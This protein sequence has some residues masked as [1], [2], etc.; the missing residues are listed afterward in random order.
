MKII[1]ILLTTIVVLAAVG[2]GIFYFGSK[3]AADEVMGQ[4][5]AELESNGQLD[6]IRQE[7]K[8]DPELQTFIAEGSTIDDRDLPFTTKDQAV[9]VLIKKFS[10]SELAELQSKMKSGMS[11]GEKQAL[12]AKYESRLSEDE[13]LALKVLAY[14]E[15]G[16]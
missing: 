7:V 6:A 12:L 1:K 9:R 11:A 8:N 13:L 14:K 4:V 16:N 10:V 3:L 15:F 2:Y 5:E